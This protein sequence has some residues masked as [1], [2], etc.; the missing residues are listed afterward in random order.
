MKKVLSSAVLCLLALCMI[1]IGFVNIDAVAFAA[2]T[3]DKDV[4]I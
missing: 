1:C 4:D 3:A 2:N